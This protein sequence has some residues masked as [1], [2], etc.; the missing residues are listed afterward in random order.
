M[1]AGQSKA[2]LVVVTG[3][4]RGVGRATAKAL[5]LEHGIEVIALSRNAAALDQLVQE[6][7]GGTGRVHPLVLD[8]TSLDAAAQVKA[9]ME[10][11]R[12]LALVHNAGQLHNVP[13]GL[14]QRR[15]LMD[16]YTT[17]VIAPLELTQ[18][19]ADELDGDPPGHIVHIGSMGGF[20]DSAKFPGL[21]AYSASKAALACMAQC[22]AEEF[23]GRG[24]RSNCLALGAVDTEM[25]RSAFPGYKA[26]V[27]ASAMGAYVAEFCLTGHKLFNGKVLPVAVSTP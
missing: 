23:K 6:C 16:L 10:G 20:Q 21:I 3:A 11:R 26:P 2:G 9:F 14:H 19:L 18:A 12:V 8:I 5:A 27:T 1:N 17:N 15:E 4:G 22:L 25:L 7:A 13:M 24:I